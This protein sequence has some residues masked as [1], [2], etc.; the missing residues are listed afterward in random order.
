[1]TQYNAALTIFVNYNAHILRAQIS[2]VSR[3]N[4]TLQ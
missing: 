3:F 4:L 2:G 1:M